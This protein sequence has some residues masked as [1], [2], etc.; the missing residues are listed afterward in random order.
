MRGTTSRTTDR[1]QSRGHA[2]ALPAASGVAR[3]APWPPL[4]LGDAGGADP[5]W[6]GFRGGGARAPSPA[7]TVL[8][9]T[10]DQV[11][12][13]DYNL[14]DDTALLTDRTFLVKAVTVMK[15]RAILCGRP[16]CEPEDLAVLRYL[17]TFR[18]PEHVHEQIDRIIADVLAEEPAPP[19]PEGASCH[20]DGSATCHACSVCATSVRQGLHVS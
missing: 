5:F 15:A 11:L 17:T 20:E 4:A 14:T 10:C 18:V 1:S 7:R 9:I 13:G 6:E 19:V 12:K 8:A 3:T 2:L 16:V